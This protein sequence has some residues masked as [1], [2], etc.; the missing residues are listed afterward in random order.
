M[1]F[2]TFSLVSC[3]AYFMKFTL[4][5]T[6]TASTA[7]KQQTATNNTIIIIVILSFLF[8]LLKT[9]YWSSFSDYDAKVMPFVYAHKEENNYFRVVISFIDVRQ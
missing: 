6:S 5:L 8:Y 1:F 7:A 4:L 9:S 2:I 3:E